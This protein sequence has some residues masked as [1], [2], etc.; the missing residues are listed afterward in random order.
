M[1][2]CVGARRGC[3]MNALRFLN[4]LSG[5]VDIGVGCACLACTFGLLNDRSLPRLNWG[6]AF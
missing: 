4:A 2:G 3:N 1:C 6:G 5:G